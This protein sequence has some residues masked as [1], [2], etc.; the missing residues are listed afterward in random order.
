MVPTSTEISD[1]YWNKCSERLPEYRQERADYDS[2]FLAELHE[3]RAHEDPFLHPQQVPELDKE[4][5]TT[6]K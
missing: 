6:L 4:F 3:R 2:T 1:L 5:Y